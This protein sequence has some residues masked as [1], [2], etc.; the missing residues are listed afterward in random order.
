MAFQ[1][2]RGGKVALKPILVPEITEYWGNG[3]TDALMGFELALALER[4][5]FMN[6]RAVCDEGVKANDSE[7]TDF[8]EAEFL[9]EQVQDIREKA[10]YVSQ[11][12][13]IGNDGHGVWHFDR[14]IGE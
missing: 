5:N 1:N 2:R 8:I 12:R 6:L 13:R 7:Y 11:L 9:H 10:I 4:L 14:E 3:K